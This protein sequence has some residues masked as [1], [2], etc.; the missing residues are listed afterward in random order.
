MVFGLGAKEEI[1]TYFNQINC[2][3]H[4]QISFIEHMKEDKLLVLIAMD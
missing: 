1:K 2:K 3:E 4:V